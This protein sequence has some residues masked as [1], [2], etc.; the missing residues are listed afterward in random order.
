VSLFDDDGARALS[1]AALLAST[2]QP[3]W[4]RAWRLRREATHTYTI[5]TTA[6]AGAAMQ[7]SRRLFFTGC[8]TVGVAMEV[9]MH[10]SGFCTSIDRMA[11]WLVGWLEADACEQMRSQDSMRHQR[12]HDQ[13]SSI[14]LVCDGGSCAGEAVA[15]LI[16]P[17]LE[18]DSAA[19][20]K[21]RPTGARSCR[22]ALLACACVCG[23][24]LLDRANQPTT[25]QLSRS[26][27]H[28]RRRSTA[29]VHIHS[30]PSETSVLASRLRFLATR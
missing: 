28:T 26:L 9:F 8:F 30:S 23:Y 17:M 22:L 27:S 12:H 16:D 14:C 11:R 24:L 13:R 5:T 21:H 10:F 1:L 18:R 2:N 19:S 6:T 29:I 25:V 7:V 15:S 3:P 4:V 20:E